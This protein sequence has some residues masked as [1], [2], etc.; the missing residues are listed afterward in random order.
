MKED[1]PQPQVDVNQIGGNDEHQLQHTAGIT[2]GT[3]QP[4]PAD[5]QPVTA[6]EQVSA[7]AT[8]DATAPQSLQESPAEAD[9]TAAKGL[10]VRLTVIQI[11]V[12]A[13]DEGISAG[14][15]HP[16]PIT[17]QHELPGNME[18][19]AC[20]T[21]KVCELPSFNSHASEDEETGLLKPP[22]PAKG[23]QAKQQLH[24]TCHECWAQCKQ[25]L[26]DPVERAA[27][28]KVLCYGAVA[29][30]ASGIMAGMTGG[31]MV[32]QG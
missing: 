19:L 24:L 1:A 5:M 10:T 21:T 13:G 7:L 26:Q 32:G 14:S 20:S 22:S 3:A 11:H 29:G 12:V 16:A 25:K 28:L 18:E 6:P 23:R 27:M 2:Q 9:C 8:P 30:T 31:V 17:Q 4:E 15:H